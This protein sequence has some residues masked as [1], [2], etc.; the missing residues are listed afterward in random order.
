MAALDSG[1]RTQNDN[2]RLQKI[3]FQPLNFI[4]PNQQYIYKKN[5]MLYAVTERFFNIYIFSGD[6]G[7]ET[8]PYP[9]YLEIWCRK[10]M[11][12]GQE[13][14]NFKNISLSRHK[15]VSNTQSCKVSSKKEYHPTPII[16]PTVIKLI[17]FLSK[18]FVCR[19]ST[20]GYT[21]KSLGKGRSSM[22]ILGEIT[23]FISHRHR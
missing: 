15:V 3:L 4:Y 13:K 19:F 22:L 18:V 14:G 5:M 10:I 7:V 20:E 16:I 6:P 9:D 2:T 21:S 1:F 17:N 12:N 11:G 23:Y 8:C